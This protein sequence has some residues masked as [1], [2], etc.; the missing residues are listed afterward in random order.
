MGRAM[1][2]AFGMRSCLIGISLAVLTSAGRG[3]QAVV[4]VGVFAGS[5][6]LALPE[7]NSGLLVD[8]VRAAFAAES[9][10]T[11]FVFLS[12]LRVEREFE[13]GHI[14]VN[15]AAKSTAAP[16]GTGVLSRWPVVSFRNQAITL[17]AKFPQLA[18]IT[19]LGALRVVTFQN[20]SRFLGADFAAMAAANKNYIEVPGS[21]PTAM[22]SLDRADVMVA[23]PD[24]FRYSVLNDQVPRVKSAVL[25]D[26]AFHDILGAGNKYWFAFRTEAMRDR[27]E[28]GIK[29]IYQNGQVDAIITRYQRDYATSR[30]FLIELDCRFKK[31]KPAA[32]ADLQ[33]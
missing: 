28:R 31:E 32:C 24:I 30:D 8:L 14:D 10:N 23:Q 26:F 1:G 15:T 18:S 20:A 5:Q 9:V 11:A 3:E 2:R 25:A 29:K 7:R 16:M 12:P 17:K 19:E 22:L 13:F 27:F 33:R 6:P 4:R 21:L